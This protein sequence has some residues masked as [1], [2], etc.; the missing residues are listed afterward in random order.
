MNPHSE[1]ELAVRHTVWV[2]LA[3][4][5]LNTDVALTRGA[6]AQ[7]LA[8]SPYDA[9]TLALILMDEVYPVCWAS[10]NAA[11][12]EA[13]HFPPDRLA[14]AIRGMD[15]ASPTVVRLRA[16]ARLAVPH[17][18]EW[19]DTLAAVAALRAG[20]TVVEQGVTQ[21]GVHR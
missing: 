13:Q 18:S 2:A 17:S 19:Q 15:P 11:Q 14:A 21:R 7:A 9:D 16:L 10:L 6:R 4:M 5:F 8:Q 12:G 20:S 3:G 1:A